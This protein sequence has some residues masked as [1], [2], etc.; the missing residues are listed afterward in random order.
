MRSKN[1]DGKRP[2]ASSRFEAVDVAIGECTMGPICFGVMCRENLLH[3]WNQN[4]LLSLSVRCCTE[5][6]YWPCRKI[7][8]FSLLLRPRPIKLI[9]TCSRTAEHEC[10]FQLGPRSGHAHP[11]R[12]L[13]FSVQ[14]IWILLARVHLLTVISRF[15][16]CP[17]H[18]PEGYQA[19]FSFLRSIASILGGV[20]TPSIRTLKTKDVTPS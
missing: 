10:L 7:P 6:R 12:R 3:S 1:G 5:T 18:P 16:K 20:Q 13:R 9:A 14:L 15:R 19:R 8:D 2:R 4:M 17:G 11:L